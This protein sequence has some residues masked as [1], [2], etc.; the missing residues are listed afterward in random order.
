ML[1][2]SSLNSFLFKPASEDEVD[3]RI[4]QLHK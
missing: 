1:R 3:K 2:N 4:S